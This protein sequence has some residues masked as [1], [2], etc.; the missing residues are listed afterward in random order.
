V[1]I[2]NNNDKTSFR[3]KILKK[4]LILMICTVGLGSLYFIKKYQENLV[5]LIPFPYYVADELKVKKSVDAPILII[6][7]IMGERL[8]SFKSKMI[9]NLSI[10]LSKPIKVISIAKKNNNIHRVLNQIKIMNRLPL[11]II[12]LGGFQEAEEKLFY[13]VHMNT[14]LENFELYN[15]NTIRTMLMIF[16]ELSRVI[17]HN[18]KRIALDSNYEI[19]TAPKADNIKQKM[20][21][22][23]YKM[24][25]AAME[26]L[27]NYITKASSLFIPIT[28]PLNL[29]LAPIAS[30]Y[31]TLTGDSAQDYV[32]LTETFNKK[33]FK[34]ALNLSSDLSLI[35]PHNAEISYMQSQI[36]RKNGLHKEAQEFAEN[37]LIYDCKRIYGN[38]VYNTI[39]KKMA[40]KYKVQYFDFHQFL[41]DKSQENVIFL[42]EIYPQDVYFNQ[43]IDKLSHVIKT[44]LR[45]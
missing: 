35:N 44:K 41:Y 27:T 34:N 9:E 40:K 45:L 23:S 15:D 33:D 24:F 30:C 19:H 43:L 36:L 21:I 3:I 28:P 7:D 29:N 37:A 42:D 17:Y 39:I 5:G 1:I 2:L 32:S 22:I 16:P 13:K 6:G 18:H 26:E 8:G 31:G 12:Y 38:K 10:N 11:I 4:I 20:N 14:I 25:E